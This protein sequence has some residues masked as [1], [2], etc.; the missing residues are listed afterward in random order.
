MFVLERKRYIGK[1]NCFKFCLD[2]IIICLER[3]L[4]ICKV[5]QLR[6]LLFYWKEKRIDVGEVIFF[7]CGFVF[8]KGKYFVYIY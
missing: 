1:K 4:E 5:R 6:Y 2:C 8:I 7:F 3:R